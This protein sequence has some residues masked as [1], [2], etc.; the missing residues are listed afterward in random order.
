MTGLRSKRKGVIRIRRDSCAEGLC[1]PEAK[2]KDLG[3]EKE[4]SFV[5]EPDPSLRSG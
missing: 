1:H 3:R 4:V 2:P 5:R